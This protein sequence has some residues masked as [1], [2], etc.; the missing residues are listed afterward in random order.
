M[1]EP[2]KGKTELDNGK[3]QK[4]PKENKKTPKKQNNNKSNKKTEKPQLLGAGLRQ[5]LGL[6]VS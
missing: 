3:E 1:K 6:C 4:N 2:L 5:E